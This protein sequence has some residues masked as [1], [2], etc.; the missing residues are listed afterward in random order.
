MLFQMIDILKNIDSQSQ[1]VVETLFWLDSVALGAIVGLFI[2]SFIY[3]FNFTIKDLYDGDYFY[4]FVG[5][6]IVVLGIG[7]YYTKINYERYIDWIKRKNQQY[8]YI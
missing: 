2:A 8:K 7:N 5:T 3:Y 4:L 6:M 1:Y